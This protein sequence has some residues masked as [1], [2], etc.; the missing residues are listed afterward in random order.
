MTEAA[1]PASVFRGGGRDVE[2]VHVPGSDGQPAGMERPTGQCGLAEGSAAD[3]YRWR[4]GSAR[5]LAAWTLSNTGGA[6]QSV[7]QTLAAPGEYQY[8][9]SVY[10]RSATPTSVAAV[11]GRPRRAT[12]CDDAS[13]RESSGTLRGDAGATS[14]RFAIETR[15]GRRGGCVRT[16]SG[17]AS[18]A[19]PYT[20][21]HTR[22]GIRRCAPWRRCTHDHDHGHQSPFL[23]GKDHS[24]KPSLN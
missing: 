5:R 6:E 11:C 14:M 17:G 2:R 18:R 24:C 12:A 8:C 15:G 1:S 3:V 13:G 10:V 23:H 9:L 21:E 16:S 20:S 4:N 19:H 7:A 22:R